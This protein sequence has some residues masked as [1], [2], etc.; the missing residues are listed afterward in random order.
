MR[1]PRCEVMGKGEG[2]IIPEDAALGQ[3]EWLREAA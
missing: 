3:G 2:S 1:N